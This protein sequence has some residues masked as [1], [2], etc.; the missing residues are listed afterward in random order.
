MKAH[1]YARIAL[2]VAMDTMHFHIAQIGLIL[3][4]LCF[5]LRDPDEQ[6]GNHEKFPGGTR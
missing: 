4:E 3:G 1:R 2:G 5:A 6:F